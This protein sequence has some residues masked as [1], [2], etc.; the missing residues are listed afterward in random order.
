MRVFLQLV[1]GDYGYRS[2]AIS[3]SRADLAK[4]IEAVVAPD[5]RSKDFVLVLADCRDEPNGGP[6]L[7]FSKAPLM[8]VASFLSLYLPKVEEVSHE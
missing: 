8:T 6:D 5:R 4:S 7:V 3:G 1:D 2:D